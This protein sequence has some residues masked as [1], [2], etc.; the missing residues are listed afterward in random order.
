MVPGKSGRAFIPSYDVTISIKS[1]CSF[2]LLGSD[3]RSVEFKKD[4]AS[5]A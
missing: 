5:A 2:V 3:S 1:K 4:I